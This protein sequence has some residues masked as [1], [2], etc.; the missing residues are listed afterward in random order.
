MAKK[1]ESARCSTCDINYP[2]DKKLCPIHGTP[3][4]KVD[5]EHDTDWPEQVARWERRIQPDSV[6]PDT[7]IQFVIHESGKKFLH[8]EVLKEAGYL[9]I[10]VGSILRLNGSFWEAAGQVFKGTDAEGWWL[11]EVEVEGVFD[12]ATPEDII[13][14]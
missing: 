14:S 6:L 10:G 12:G 7:Q 4:W 9:H 13:D 11:E 3:T 5:D 8:D 1:V 2:S